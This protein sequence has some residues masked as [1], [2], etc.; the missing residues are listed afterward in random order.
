MK[1]WRS[2]ELIFAH[3]NRSAACSSGVIDVFN[4]GTPFASP[5]QF[6]NS[7]FVAELRFLLACGPL[8]AG[9]CAAACFLYVQLGTPVSSNF[10]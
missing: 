2:S 10:E 8:T 6:L 4:L 7:L 5:K 3:H 9:M 1:D